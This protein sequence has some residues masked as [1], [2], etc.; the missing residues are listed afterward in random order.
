M[1]ILLI[2]P[3][4]PSSFW[5]MDHTLDILGKSAWYPPLGLLTVA[6]M[7]PEQWEQRLI[8]LN[9]DPLLDT[10][11]QWADYVFLSA[12]NVQENSAKA[13]IQRCNRLEVPVVA[14]GSLFTLEYQRFEGVAHFILNEAEITL[15]PFL[16]DL[17]AGEPKPVYEATGYADT[18]LTPQPA[19]QHVDLK[20]Y[21]YGIIQYSRGCPFHCDF[22]DVPVLYGN[23]PRTKT[24]SQ[25]IA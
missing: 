21:Q 16:E 8:D 23:N 22:C 4:M 18:H 5:S 14:G 11:I 9:V 25:I 1:K 12:M 2:Y 17:A 10:D 24:V 15:P 19:W 13:L 7:L 20:R 6:S 3:E